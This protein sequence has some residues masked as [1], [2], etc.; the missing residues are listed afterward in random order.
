VSVT[1]TG[2]DEIG[3]LTAGYNALGD[4]LRRER[5]DLYQREL[6]LDTVVQTTPLALVLT[7]ANDSIVFGN[8]AAR[9]LFRGG[10]KLEGLNQVASAIRAEGAIPATIAVLYGRIKVGLVKEEIELLAGLGQQGVRKCSRRDL[11]T[12][13]VRNGAT[14]VAGTMIVAY[15]AGI[16]VFATGG[17]GASRPPVDVLAI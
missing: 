4:S 14:T 17:S 5:L 3:D 2:P 1:A 15:R 11:P 13:W 6:L 12:C 10:R 16:K 9:Q 8:I 7:N